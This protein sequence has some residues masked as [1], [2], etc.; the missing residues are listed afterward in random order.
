M[1]RKRYGFKKKGMNKG[2]EVKKKKKRNKRSNRHYAMNAKNPRH[3]RTNW[4]LPKKI[5]KRFKHKAIIATWS[6]DEDISSEDDGKEEKDRRISK[7]LSHG[8]LGW[9]KLRKLWWLY[10]WWITWCFFELLDDIKNLNFKNKELKRLINSLIEKKEI[11]QKKIERILKEQNNL[12]E[13]NKCLQKKVDKLKTI[14]DRFSLSLKN[15]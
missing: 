11:F 4:S 12:V 6:N 5:F 3:F 8:K 13:K 7:L 9:G 10:F 15:L 1:K 2:K 14:I